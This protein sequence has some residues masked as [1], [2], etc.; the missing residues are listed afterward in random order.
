MESTINSSLYFNY[1]LKAKSVDHNSKGKL[2]VSLDNCH[3]TSGGILEDIKVTL[4]GMVKYHLFY[5]Y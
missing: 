4:K 1:S 3:D 5:L 2:G